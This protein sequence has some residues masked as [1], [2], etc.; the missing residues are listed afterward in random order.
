MHNHIVVLPGMQQAAL[1][2]FVRT[3]DWRVTSQL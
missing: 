3:V 1:Q 2:A